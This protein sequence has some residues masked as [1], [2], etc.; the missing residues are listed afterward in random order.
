MSRRP[1]Y[2]SR[3][4]RYT[5]HRRVEGIVTAACALFIILAGAFAFGVLLCAGEYQ[6]NTTAASTEQK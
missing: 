1:T 3:L 6:P 4:E 5:H 2:G